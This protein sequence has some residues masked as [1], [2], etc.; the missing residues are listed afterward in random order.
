MIITRYELQHLYNL[1]LEDGGRL[2]K[3]NELESFFVSSPSH[4]VMLWTHGQ[5]DDVIPYN[6]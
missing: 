5:M 4:H 2:P 6:R 1:D 3:K